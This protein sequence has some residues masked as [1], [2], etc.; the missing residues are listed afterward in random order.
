MSSFL[1]KIK[2]LPYE[3]PFFKKESFTKEIKREGG[4]TLSTIK[5]GRGKENERE[6]NW[7]S[8]LPTVS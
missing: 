2:V 7:K 5:R 4:S 1:K 8:M 3:K 6:H